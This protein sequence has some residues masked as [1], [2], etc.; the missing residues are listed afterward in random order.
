[1]GGKPGEESWKP[2]MEGLGEEWATACQRG[3]QD[4]EDG[5]RE[6]PTGSSNREVTVDVSKSS[7]MECLCWEWGEAGQRVGHKNPSGGTSREQGGVS[8]GRL[9]RSKVTRS[10]NLPETEGFPGT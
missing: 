4:R 8:T 10:P 2:V 3:W 5:T 1:M 6:Q 7:F 9:S